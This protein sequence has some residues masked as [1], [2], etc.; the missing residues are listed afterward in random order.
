MMGG[1]KRK[2]IGKLDYFGPINQL[3][4]IINNDRKKTEVA[5][6]YLSSK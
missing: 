4:I 2:M 3:Y 5:K 1:R 6:F